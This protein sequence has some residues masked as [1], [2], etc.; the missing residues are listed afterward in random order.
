MEKKKLALI[1]LILFGVSVVGGYYLYNCVNEDRYY[2]SYRL[3]SIKM[4]R[5]NE[6]SVSALANI[7]AYMMGNGT[8]S[9]TTEILDIARDNASS[10]LTNNKEMRNIP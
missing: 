7:F 3:E 4:S 8:S 1:V 2:E 6:Q 9:N 5:A 10:A